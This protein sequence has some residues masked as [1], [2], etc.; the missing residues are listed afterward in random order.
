MTPTSPR[1]ETGSTSRPTTTGGGPR[2]VGSA[3]ISRGR[4]SPPPS[5]P[6]LG[7]TS[8]S[9]C[10]RSTSG[11]RRR[12]SRGASATD[13]ACGTWPCPPPI[14]PTS[15]SRGSATT[16][17]NRTA[18]IASGT[19]TAT[20]TAMGLPST[21]NTRGSAICGSPP[22]TPTAATRINRARSWARSA[23]AT[24]RSTS[25]AWACATA[26]GHRVP[27]IA[28]VPAPGTPTGSGRRRVSSSC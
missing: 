26:P 5:T 15:N 16:A 7:P 23:S 18:A 1:P 20:V 4:T 8:G 27:T 3:S 12:T 2:R 22:T 11:I 14:S 6:C 13:A 10:S 24:R 21:S 28:L 19:T 17:S 25:T 9:A